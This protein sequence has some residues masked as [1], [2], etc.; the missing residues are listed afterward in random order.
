MQFLHEYG[1]LILILAIF[2]IL[3]YVLRLVA[4]RHAMKKDFKMPNMTLY[5]LTKVNPSDDNVFIIYASDNIEEAIV[6]MT[7]ETNRDRDNHNENIY[8]IV[9]AT[10]GLDMLIK[11]E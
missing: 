4:T 7:E 6:K 9:T 8:K 11:G 2:S 10:L 3:Q 1:I 5:F